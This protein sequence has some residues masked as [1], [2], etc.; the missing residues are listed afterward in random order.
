MPRPRVPL[1]TDAGKKN[2]KIRP[3][4]L[5]CGRSRVRWQK[6]ELTAYDFAY[7]ETPLRPCSNRRGSGTWKA[8][9]SAGTSA[10]G[11][12]EAR[13]VRLRCPIAR[14]RDAGSLHARVK[15]KS[16]DYNFIYVFA[17]ADRRLR[18]K[19]AENTAP[20]WVRIRWAR[21]CHAGRLE[22]VAQDCAR[23]KSELPREFSMPSRPPTTPKANDPEAAKGK[24][25]PMIDRVG[26]Q[27]HRES[28]P[29]WL[30]LQGGDLDY[31]NVPLEYSGSA[32]PGGQLAPYW[33]ANLRHPGPAFC[34]DGSGLYVFQF[35]RSGCRWRCAGPRGVAPRAGDGV[36]LFAEDVASFAN[37]S[38]VKANPRFRR[39]LRGTIRRFG[40]AAFQ[41]DPARAQALL[42]M[43][44]FVDR[45]G[46][47]FGKPGWYAAHH[48]NGHRA[49]FDQQ[50]I[51]RAVEQEPPAVGV[52][53]KFKIAKWQEL[54]KQAKAGQLQMWQLA[55]NATTRT[56]R[57]SCKTSMAPTPGKATTPT[58]VGRL[59]MRFTTRRAPCRHRPRRDKLYAEM[60][61]LIA[62]Y[63]PWIPQ[64]HR[65]RSEI[66]HPWVVGYKK[67][68]LYK[69]GSVEST[70]TK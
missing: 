18:A 20:M 41:Y 35:Q 44:G 13:H 15:L 60:N 6:R 34:R 31:G 16:T 21:G 27:H 36:Q 62:V 22:E 63:V 58:S 28:Q 2:T 10:R 12:Q 37:G 54:N 46:D 50:T 45:D 7:S 40:T 49:G 64:T 24:R 38:A 32:F 53:M 47:G 69:Q 42:D 8:R 68:P 48:R 56:A 26:G 55:W 5:L 57:I 65:Q 30:A 51:Q 70:W 3:T 52:R 33:P 25:L 19:V 61:R 59:L 17:T 23:Q 29:R 9:S 43:A 39:A 67:H 66:A 1:V 11:G 4:I 14:H